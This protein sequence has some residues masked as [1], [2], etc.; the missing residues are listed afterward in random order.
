MWAN[1]ADA[2]VRGNEIEGTIVARNFVIRLPSFGSIVVALDRWQRF[3]L[4][5]CKTLYS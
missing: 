2:A 4:A 5:R 1:G 3:G